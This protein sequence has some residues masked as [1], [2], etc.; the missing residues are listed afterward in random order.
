MKETPMS[1]SG[2][3]VTAALFLSI[4]SDDYTLAAD[5]LPY[6]RWINAAHSAGQIHTACGVTRKDRPIPV[7]LT[8]GMLDID[9]RRTR[10]LLIGGFD[11]D[12]R[13]IK[14]T[15]AAWTAFHALPPDSKMRRDFELA[16]IPVANPDS[17]SA[18]G[19]PLNSAGGT[20][21]RGYPP[22]AKAYNDPRN[23]ETIYLWRWMAMLGPDLVIVVD[24]GEQQQWRGAPQLQSI[25]PRLFDQ[26]HPVP[27]NNS[28]RI[29]EAMTTTQKDW[30]HRIPAVEASVPDASQ[31]LPAVLEA[32]RGLRSPARAELQ[33]RRQRSPLQ[34]AGQLSRFYGHRL[35]SVTYI[36]ALALIGRLRLGEL[37]GDQQHAQD[38]RRIVTPYLDG[39]KPTFGKRPSG[40]HLSGHLVFGELAVRTGDQRFRQRARQAAELG[41]TDDGK[42]RASMPFHNEMSDAVFM[43]TPILVQVGRLTG[44]SRYYDMA[45]RHL[46][47]M[48]RMNLR[49]D[50]LHQHSPL[51]PAGTAWGRGNGFPALGLALCLSDLPADNPHRPL[52]LD[53]YRKHIAAMLPHQDEMGMWHQVVDHPESYREFTVTCMTTFAIARGLRRG[54]LDGNIH[55]PI[56]RQAWKSIQC[57][58]GTGPNLVDVCT[59]TGK[60][61]SF[62]RYL[63]RPANFGRDDRGGAMALLVST[64]LAFA[65]RE[66][67]LTL[68]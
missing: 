48:L 56:V 29:A 36:P 30:P 25:A 40:S 60:Q 23:P 41:F 67:V 68:D 62:R 19:G 43:G 11:G 55:T 58:I 5:G 52:F 17:A 57:R 21:G 28:H 63:D 34:I 32:A 53:T 6:A 7:L 37:T 51:D 1:R 45:A 18:G 26:L 65:V 12:A 24:H 14:Q 47:F 4:F 3:L 50:G 2:L 64:E 31:F 46:R 49:D 61:P 59:G 38:V 9:S 13:S 22:T 33:R 39:S 20:P 27:L 54:W 35:D 8:P 16:V 42:L 44:E 10:V 15:L 66:R